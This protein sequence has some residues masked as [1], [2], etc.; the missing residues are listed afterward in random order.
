MSGLKNL[1]KYG[2]LW[3]EINNRKIGIGKKTALTLPKKFRG[4]ENE[5][6]KM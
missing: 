2:R 5:M 1:K 3:I 4:N 6:N